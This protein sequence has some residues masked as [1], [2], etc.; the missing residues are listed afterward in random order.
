MRIEMVQMNPVV[1][2]IEVNMEDVLR[3][4]G[5]AEERADIVVFPELTLVGYPA[6]DILLYLSLLRRH[7]EALQ[8]IIAGS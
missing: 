5:A 8:K 4:Y 2:D 6:Q 7:E 3:Y 1:G